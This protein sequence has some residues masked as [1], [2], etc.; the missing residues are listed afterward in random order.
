MKRLPLWGFEHPEKCPVDIINAS[1]DALRALQRERAGRPPDA[2]SPSGETEEVLY[3]W[4]CALIG[5]EARSKALG[6][7]FRPFGAPSP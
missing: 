7:L 1:L 5:A 3:E 6:D 2:G 4:F